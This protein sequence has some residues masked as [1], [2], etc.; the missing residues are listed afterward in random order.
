MPAAADPELALRLAKE[1]AEIY[2]QAVD[3]MLTIVARRLATGMER[4]DW[5]T[6]K[7]I[8]ATQLR[9][10]AQVIVDRLEVL[11]PQAA[12]KAIDAAWTAG[13]AQGAAEL[14]LTAALTTRTHTRAVDALVRETVGSL[15]R[16]HLQILRSVDD[17]YRRVITETSSGVLTGTQTRRQVAQRAL[18]RFAQ[19]GITGFVDRAGRNWQL[20]SYAEMSVRTASGR[21]QVEG[22]LDRFVENGRDLV[23]ISDAPAE[24][25]I[26]RPYEGSIFS[27]SGNDPDYPPLSSALGL[28]HANC[29]HV[30]SAF[31]PGLTRRMRHTAD[32]KGDA[33]R[34]EQRRLE[35]GVRSWKRR[36]AVALDDDAKRAASAHAREWQARL[37]AHV[38]ENDLKRLRYREQIG[39]AR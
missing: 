30:A 13:S 18:D 34:Q 6:R 1:T 27:I 29:R 37:K 7:L 25:S 24:C 5:S 38:D 10:E 39:R 15:E 20:D 28:F 11:G 3:D 21:A 8:E 31:T 22:T 26:C 16:S 2:G 12:E 4:P 32:P 23:I 36:S 17:I 14:N 9:N 35:R 33:L 19:R